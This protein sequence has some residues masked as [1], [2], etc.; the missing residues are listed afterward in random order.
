MNKDKISVV[1]PIYNV[2][3]W[4]CDCIDS[5]LNQSLQPFEII[6][7]NDGSTDNSGEICNQYASNNSIIKVVHKVN[8]GLSSAR[9]AGIELFTGDY[10]VFIDSDD[11]IHPAFLET[12]YDLAIRTSADI[13][14]CDYISGTVCK[15]IENETIEEIRYNEDVLNKMNDNDVVITVA[16]NKLYKAYFFKELGLRYKEG[17]IHEDMFMS[18][19]LLYNA[20]KIAITNQK[21]YFYRQ[22]EN[23]IMNLNFSIKKLDALEAINY[24]IIFF[25]EINN[26]LLFNIECNSLIRKSTYLLNDLLRSNCEDKDEIIS[27]LKSYIKLIDKNKDRYYAL[28]FK[29]KI[30]LFLLKIKMWRM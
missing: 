10:V 20:K 24:R 25:K 23:S 13:T 30:K 8:G 22:R 18:P 5:V 1:L 9:N 17:K 3:E 15:W 12:L 14:M 6:L 26:K 21:L 7:V 28:S 4:L 19:H 2:S 29:Y 27:I 16:W 11:T